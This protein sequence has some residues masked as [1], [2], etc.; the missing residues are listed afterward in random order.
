MH[1]HEAIKTREEE[2]LLWLADWLWKDKS[3]MGHG[4]LR[5][6]DTTNNGCIFVW[7]KRIFFSSDTPFEAWLVARFRLGRFSAKKIIGVA[8]SEWP[9]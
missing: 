1:C 6:S 3:R 7:N 8:P 9:K 5:G 4:L 2:V